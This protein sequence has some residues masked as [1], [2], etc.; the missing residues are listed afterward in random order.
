MTEGLRSVAAATWRAGVDFVYERPCPRCRTE[1]AHAPS[2]E[3]IWPWLCAG[4]AADLAP[5]LEFACFR[6]G[7][8]A[9][10]YLDTTGGCVHCRDDRFAFERAVAL[11]V[12]DEALRLACLS[13]KQSGAEPFAAALAHVLWQRM[14]AELLAL[15]ADAVVAVPHHWIV[16]LCRGHNPAATI[17]GVLA[18]R[19][20]RPFLRTGLKKIRHTP[21]QTGL[22]RTE[23]R[24]NLRGAFRAGRRKRLA[25]RRVLLVDDVLTTGTTAHRA[26]RA[27]LDG[28]AASAASVVVAVIAR[29]IGRGTT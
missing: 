15:D 25:G 24:A 5:P 23:R 19:L 20:R 4:C 3:P 7:A 16:R 6:C 11:G 10:P 2:A 13:I 17:A 12:Y 1:L 18:A 28:G 27:L 9:G 14:S 29:G 22:T 26:A 8:P 21:S